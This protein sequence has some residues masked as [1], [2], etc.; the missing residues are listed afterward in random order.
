VAKLAIARVCLFAILGAWLQLEVAILHS[1]VT[2][3]KVPITI[4]MNAAIPGYYVE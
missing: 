4:G 3:Q 2:A 1:G